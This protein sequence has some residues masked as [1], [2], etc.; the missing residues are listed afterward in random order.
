MTGQ[1]DTLDDRHEYRWESLDLIPVSQPRRRR[2]SCTSLTVTF[3]RNES[4]EHRKTSVTRTPI[5]P[6]PGLSAGKVR[7][8]GIL[9]E[10]QVTTQT[11]SAD[12]SG[13]LYFLLP[14][15]LS[16]DNAVC[17]YQLPVL[18]LWNCCILFSFCSVTKQIPPAS[19]N[20][21][22]VRLSVMQE[23]NIRDS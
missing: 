8:K 19:E 9:L 18:G 13:I 10:K 17:S 3:D 21:K 16:P 5:R 23:E 1:T 7:I 15:E 22:C 2:L 11:E 6:S 20:Y 14:P 4:Q 12:T